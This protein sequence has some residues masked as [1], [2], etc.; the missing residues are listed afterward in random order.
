MPV[1]GRGGPDKRGGRGQDHAPGSTEDERVEAL[2]KLK[3]LHD[4]G[5]LTEEQY[6]AEKR[7]ILRRA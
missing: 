1:I 4:S 5:V 2:V 6:E 3:E 7:K